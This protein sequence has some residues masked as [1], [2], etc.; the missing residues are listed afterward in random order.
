M[1]QVETQVLAECA[2]NME[3]EKIEPVQQAAA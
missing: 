1:H 3:R 2:M